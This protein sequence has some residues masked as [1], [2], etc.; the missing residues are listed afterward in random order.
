MKTRTVKKRSESD[1]QI[2]DDRVEQEDVLAVL[3][4]IDN[5]HEY[6]MAMI[7]SFRLKGREYVVMYNYE[8]DDGQHAE[9]EIIIL[10]SVRHTNGEQY[11]MSIKDRRELDSAFGIFFRRFEEAG[12]L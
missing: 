6:Y 12:R 10:R 1:S 5:G 8:P 3:V 7:D 11:F 2:R 9:P 4:D